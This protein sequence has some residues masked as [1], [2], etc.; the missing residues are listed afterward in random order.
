MIDLISSIAGNLA[1]FTAAGRKPSPGVSSLIAGT[2]GP[3]FLLSVTQAGT[4]TLGAAYDASGLSL[5][6]PADS[7]AGRQRAAAVK[8]AQNDLQ[9]GRMADARKTAEGLLRRNPGDTTALYLI[10]RSY[11]A[12]GSYQNA[13]LFLARAAAATSDNALIEMD[14]HAARILQRGTAAAVA[15]VERLLKVNRDETEGLRLANYVLDAEPGNLDVYLTLADHYERTK[16]LDL[17]GVVF[18][19]ALKHVPKDRQDALLTRLQRFAKA[20]PDDPGSHDL[21]ARAYAAAGRLSEAEAS[22][23]RAL[24]LSDGDPLFETGLKADFAD[25]HSQAGREALARGDV[26]A[27]RRHFEKAIR[28]NRDDTRRNDLADLEMSVGERA[29]RANH[30]RGALRAFGKAMANLPVFDTE[31]RSERL[32]RLYEKLAGRFADN[33][34]LERVVSARNG[35]YLLDPGNEERKRGL[36]DAHDA[37]GLSLF[38]QGKYRE[39]VRA[40]KQALKLFSGDENYAAHL[41]AAQQAMKP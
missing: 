20:H 13:E 35:A 41:A 22:F 18:T 30:L 5:L 25:I 2:F 12:E 15:E 23:N 33:G 21:L 32:I 16:R 29:L 1:Q 31:K 27:A 7:R 4:Q 3:D 11:L 37:Y 10:G 8:S 38:E 34:D 28:L 39:A 14:L 17:A 40:F 24:E 26:S 6:P 9:A 36:A 19:D